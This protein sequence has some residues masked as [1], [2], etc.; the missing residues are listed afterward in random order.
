MLGRYYSVILKKREV[1]RLTRS[2]KSHC[3]CLFKV[4]LHT[5]CRCVYFEMYSR[6]LKRL[7]LFLPIILHLTS[8]E[9][10]LTFKAREYTQS[11]RTFYI[12]HVVFTSPIAKVRFSLLDRVDVLTNYYNYMREITIS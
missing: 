7:Y 6:V 9:D 5:H 11:K 12:I 4:Y 3:K 2:N 10:V 8:N 1:N